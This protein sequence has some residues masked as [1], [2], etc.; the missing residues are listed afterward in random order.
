MCGIW[1][2]RCIALQKEGLCAEP[3]LWSNQLRELCREED[4]SAGC[5][6]GKVIGQKCGNTVSVPQL[7]RNK[8]VSLTPTCKT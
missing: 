6:C 4:C 8:R 5:H 1:A 2:V 3:Q 7:G